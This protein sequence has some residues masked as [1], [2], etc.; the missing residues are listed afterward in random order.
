MPSGKRKSMTAE[1]KSKIQLLLVVAI[2]VSGARAGYVIYQRHAEKVE[3]SKKQAPPLNPDY[4][5]VVK[6]LYPHDLESARGLTQQPVWVKE[7]YRFSYYPYDRASHRLD[8][9][10]SAG[11]LLPI[12][13]MQFKDVVVAPSPAAHE[14]MLVAVFE[15]DNKQYGLQIGTLANGNYQIYSDELF[16]VQDPHDLYKHWPAD[17]WNAIEQRQMKVG[18]N[19]M[20]ADFA[21]GMGIP[22]RSSDP[23]LKTVTYPNGGKPLVIT[24]RDGRAAEIKPGQP[25]SS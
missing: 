22:D 5:V 1:L 23:A 7:G 13:K 3:E 24:Y 18:M 9:S 14:K 11:M 20:Q 2:A 15:R 4:Y 17:V 12:E 10:H 19:E 25:P 21:I 16:F 6:K 8:M